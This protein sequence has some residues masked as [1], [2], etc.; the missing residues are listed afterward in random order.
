VRAVVH[1]RYGP[2]DVLRVEEVERPAPADDEVLV[3]VH[4]STVN[5]SDCGFRS[6]EYFITRF[7]TGLLRPKN[8]F[9]GSEFAGVVAATGSAVTE[10]AVDDHVFGLR[11]GANAEFLVMPESGPIAPMPKGLSF[12]QA[13]AVGD[14]ALTALAFLRKTGVRAG[15][16]IVVYGASGSIGTAAVQLAKHLGARVTAVCNAKNVELVRSL[17]ADEV[18]DYERDD[19]TKT[20]RRYDVFFDSVGK[21]SFRRCRSTLKPGARWAATGG[22]ANLLW[23]VWPWLRGHVAV[24]LAN[25]Q[26]TKPDLLLLKEL[27]ERGEYRPVIDRT[28]ALDDVLDATRYVETQQKTGNVVL[29][30]R[31]SAG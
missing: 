11:H 10:F 23:A 8:K 15:S 4:T 30:I 7:F 29:T 1:D 3:E 18:L 22:F 21:A 17:G 19:L 20:G 31:G 28:Y 25:A 12:G 13:A 9:V 16:D 2:P 26:F 24:V 27:I 14:G 5:R 6:A